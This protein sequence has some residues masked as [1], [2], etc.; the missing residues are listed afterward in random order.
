MFLEEGNFALRCALVKALD[1]VIETL[2]VAL[3]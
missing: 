1:E 3:P 2:M